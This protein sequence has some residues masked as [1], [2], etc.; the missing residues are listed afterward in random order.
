[1]Q[2]FVPPRGSNLHLLH[3]SQALVLHATWVVKIAII[4]LNRKIHCFT[5]EKY[6]THQNT[7]L[8]TTL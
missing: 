3:L 2:T 8:I 1:M 4:F 5:A 6:T 7:A